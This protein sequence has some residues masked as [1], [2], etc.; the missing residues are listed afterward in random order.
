MTPI[1]K[2]AHIITHGVKVGSSIVYSVEVTKDK[3]VIDL[4]QE[5]K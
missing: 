4:E 1:E 5:E 3:S 2:L